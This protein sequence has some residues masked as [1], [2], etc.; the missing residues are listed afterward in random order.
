MQEIFR[1]LAAK[2]KKHKNFENSTECGPSCSPGQLAAA[3][4]V[5]QPAVDRQP[6]NRRGDQEEVGR[7][8][9]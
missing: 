2:L 4:S 9:P 6:D 3:G 7:N 8:I 1:F 5:L